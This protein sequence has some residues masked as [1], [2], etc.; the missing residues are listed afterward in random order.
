ML[1]ANKLFATLDTT[2]RILHPES[3]PR[4]LVSDTVGFIK[5]LPHGL[6]ASF[7][8]ARRGIGCGLLRLR[9]RRQRPG[10]ERQLAVTDAVLG[11]I[12]ADEGARLRIFNKIDHVGDAAAEAECRAALQASYPDCVVMSARRP[13]MSPA[14]T[15]PSSI[16]SSAICSEAG[17]VPA[18]VGPAIAPRNL[19]QLPGAGWSVPTRR[20]PSSRCAAGAGH[21]GQPASSLPGLAGRA[22]DAKRQPAKAADGLRLCGYAKGGGT[23][24][25]RPVPC[26]PAGNWA[27]SRCR[28]AIA[29][30]PAS[31]CLFSQPSSSSSSRS[32]LT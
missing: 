26:G 8:D 31:R 24:S 4:V 2:V 17:A 30:F 20:A 16:S 29:G 9:H 32:R 12:G 13:T 5:N 19:R 22:T 10:F 6:V 25:R 21:A 18:L 28:S 7:V 11:E 1:V 14:R 15:G 3:V 27:G 23:F